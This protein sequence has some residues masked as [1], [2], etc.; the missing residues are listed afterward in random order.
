MR[1]SLLLVTLIGV[2]L[3][4]LSRQKQDLRVSAHA[5]GEYQLT[6]DSFAF[7]PA[8]LTINQGET[9]T[10]VNTSSSEFIEV[11]SNPH[12][13]HTD[14][15][16][17]NLGVVAPGKS[18]SS[19]F[20]IP[21]V[22]NWHDH[23]HPNLGGSITVAGRGDLDYDGDVDITDFNQMRSVFNTADPIADLNVSG[24][25][26]IFDYSILVHNLGI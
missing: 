23:L 22:F 16:E 17:L 26:D 4:L 19:V 6:F 2:G 5:L 12:P 9:V 10:W 24:V 3:L 15:P 1:K 7:T 8:T 21:G 13:I 25:V 11:A 20:L 18:V 14:N